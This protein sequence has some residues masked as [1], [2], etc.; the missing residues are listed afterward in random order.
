MLSR[1]KTARGFPR[2]VFGYIAGEF[3][4]SFLISFLFFFVVF[5]INQILLLAEDILAKNA[6]LDQ[7]ILLLIYSLPSVVAIAFPFA[8][9]SGALMTS[10]RLNTDNE[11]LAFSSLGIPPLALYAPFLILGVVIASFSFIANDFFLPRSAKSFKVVYAKLVEASASIELEPYSIKRYNDLVVV[12][13]EKKEGEIGDL[14]LF[15]TNSK[16][17]E[18]FIWA[19]GASL[20]IDK[21][22]SGAVITMK[23]IL[24]HKVKTDAEEGFSVSSADSLEYR[25]TIHQPIVGFSNTGPSEMSSRELSQAIGRKQGLLDKRIS[26]ADRQKS[27]SRSELLAIYSREAARSLEEPESMAANSELEKQLFRSLSSFNQAAA[28]AP[29]DRS[30]QLYKLEY[31]KKFAIPAAGFFFALLAFPL[32]L[33]TKKAGRTAGFGIALILSTLYWGLLF[34]GQTLGLRSSISPSLAMWLPNILVFFAAIS[35]IVFRKS[36]ARRII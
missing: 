22:N 23:D 24:E 8:S 34:A 14:L 4:L 30:L 3:F 32:G 11:I 17:G 19:E 5:F 10:A 36:G 1:G 29:M 35:M 15:E 7:T 9:L 26:D 31:S 12:T 6:P 21:E 27:E 18:T 2:T 33:G 28:L 13:G 16:T 25:F 20:S